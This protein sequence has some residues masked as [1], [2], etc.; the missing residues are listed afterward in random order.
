M[1]DGQAFVGNRSSI[2]FHFS[3][4]SLQ[5]LYCSRKFKQRRIFDKLR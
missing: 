5:P 3:R 4:K 2:Q 1:Q